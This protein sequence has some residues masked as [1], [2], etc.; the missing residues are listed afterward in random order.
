MLAIVKLVREIGNIQNPLVIEKKDISK[1]NI[2]K[3]T[4]VLINP[5]IANLDISNI[6]S[7]ILWYCLTILYLYITYSHLM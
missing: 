7:F 6:L 1:F 3:S 4:K 5:I 2:T